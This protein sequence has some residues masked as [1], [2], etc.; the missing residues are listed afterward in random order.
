MPAHFERPGIR[1]T[2]DVMREYKGVQLGYRV[3]GQIHDGSS[4]LPHQHRLANRFSR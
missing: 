2:A 1:K 3:C 4:G